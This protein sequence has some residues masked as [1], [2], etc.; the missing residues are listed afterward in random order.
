MD[1]VVSTYFGGRPPR[2]VTELLSAPCRAG[3]LRLLRDVAEAGCLA[4]RRLGAS[5]VGDLAQADADRGRGFLALLARLDA[6]ASKQEEQYLLLTLLW[7]SPPLAAAIGAPPTLWDEYEFSSCGRAQKGRR[8]VA[9]VA[10]HP[11]EL[12]HKFVLRHAKTC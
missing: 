8:C 2:G 12:Y 4:T 5:I 10:L 1:R 9:R 3:A 6:G 7:L 11:I